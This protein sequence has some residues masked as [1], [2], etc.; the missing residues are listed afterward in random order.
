[1][2]TKPLFHGAISAL[3]T[4]FQD[5]K[6]DYQSLTNLIEWQ[7]SSSIDGIVVCGSTGEGIT[8]EESERESIIKH[9]VSVVNK[10]I[11]VMV[12]T[13]SSSTKRTIDYT[14]QASDL[15]ADAALI[16]TPYYNKPTQE[17]LFMHFKAVN[18]ETNIPIYLYTNPGR[19]IV[20]IT[21]PTFDR[22]MDLK[23]IVGVKESTSNA[24]FALSIKN[25]SAQKKQSFD[26]LCGDDSEALEYNK[27]GSLGCISVAS[28]LIPDVVSKIQKLSLGGSHDEAKALY[29]KYEPI[30][31]C[32]FVETNP[33]PLKYALSLI[34]KCSAEMRLPL[35]EPS[36]ESKSAIKQSMIECGLL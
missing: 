32:L 22:L 5:G 33:T 13:G 19:A 1:M 14:Q 15:G 16:V 28:N 9:S 29:K 11:P 4:P 12:G 20:S 35:V 6:V 30:F 8:L 7:I 34:G 10:R 26:I 21:L 2:N 36:E 17:G 24:E 27:N 31:S 18:D 23:N 3:V 25:L